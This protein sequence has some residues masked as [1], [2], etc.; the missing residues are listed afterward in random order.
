MK[1]AGAEIPATIWVCLAYLESLGARFSAAKVCSQDNNLGAAGCFVHFR[2]QNDPSSSLF[3]QVSKTGLMELCR[4]FERARVEALR[5]RG[6]SESE[7]F[8]LAC[9]EKLASLTWT[10]DNSLF[11]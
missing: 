4:R 5:G 9:Y 6:N 2:E 1:V 7:P 8:Q 10:A 11:Q 3:L